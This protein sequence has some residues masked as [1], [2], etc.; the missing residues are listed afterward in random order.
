[1]PDIATGSLG[2]FGVFS[3]DDGA[4]ISQLANWAS[5]ETDLGRRLVSLPDITGDGRADLLAS[6]LGDYVGTESPTCNPP[7]PLN[8][9]GLIR[10]FSG[11][12]LSTLFTKRST[13]VDNHR[14]MYGY[15]VDS[16]GDINGDG[17]GE[18]LVS[19]PNEHPTGCSG[20]PTGSVRIYSGETQ[21]ILRTPT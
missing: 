12:S 6:G 2:A 14:D 20:S 9:R 3:G 21:E 11:Q 16:L 7:M 17:I 8:V 13:A 19:A 15:T 4:L 18:F 1:M 5:G 10:V